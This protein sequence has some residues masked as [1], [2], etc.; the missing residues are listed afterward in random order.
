MGSGIPIQDGTS[1]NLAAVD[2]NGNVAM[3][4]PKTPATIGYQGLAA[5]ISEG[6]TYP[7]N[8]PKAGR[9]IDAS[10]SF[11][12]R[13]GVDSPLLS[14]V[15]PGSAIDLNL[16]NQSTATMTVAV[17]GGFLNLNSGNS[18]ATTV[19]AIVKSYR[20]FP[21]WH[22]LSTRFDCILQFPAVAQANTVM[23]W[24]LFLAATTAAPT[25][26]VL[27]RVNGAGNFMAVVN[28]S[29]TENTVDLGV[30]I[31]AATRYEFAVL[32]DRNQAEFYINN[33]L[34][35]TIA[36]PTAG[37]V[38]TAV[39][40]QPVCF[41]I[42]NTGS[43]PALA[44]QIKVSSCCVILCD[45]GAG[46]LWPHALVGMGGNAAQLSFNGGATAQ[47]AN[48][49]NNTA[50]AS[51]TLSNTAAGYATLGGQWQFAAVAGA[52]TDYA[53]FALQVPAATAAVLGRT[54]YVTGI[55]IDSFNT[56]T[57]V[58]TTATVLQWGI[59]AGSSA[60]T[61]VGTVDSA[62]VKIAR[63][64]TLGVQTF[65]IGAAVGAS[66]LPGPI[67]TQ[68]ASPLVVNAGEYLHVILKMPIGT[69]T[70]SQIIRGT[71]FI[72]GYFE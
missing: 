13:V 39:S 47:T 69:N 8:A 50:P 25:D 71:C 35:A 54:L 23:E 6:V 17:S 44:N 51:A 68:F 72:N 10:D 2:T 57:A 43:A 61:L 14:A 24:G 15:F 33:V 28:F 31:T 58:A 3:T 46:R 26:G 41:R 12:L 21:L 4:G 11:R 16:W 53:L 7:T 1:G 66:P 9:H 67:D 48:Y 18:V 19:D 60:V 55:R 36:V 29:G 32:I 45:G 64:I 56:G 62:G 5:I 59:S 38:S 49:V 37:A 22:D 65:A 20:A 63:R 40:D 34:C 27:F 30:A 70:A 52:E 42:Y